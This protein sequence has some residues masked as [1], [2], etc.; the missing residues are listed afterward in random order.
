MERKF[1]LGKFLNRIRCWANEE[2]F[3]PE[4]DEDE[5]EEDDED[6][7]DDLLPRRRVARRN[8][9]T[10]AWLI[11]FESTKEDKLNWIE[12]RLTLPET[13]K[14]KTKNYLL[15]LHYILQIIIRCVVYGDFNLETWDLR[16]EKWQLLRLKVISMRDTCHKN[17]Y[18]LIFFICLFLPNSK[19]QNIP[20][21]D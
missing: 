10:S 2:Y 15:V 8:T 7:K 18:A 17:V 16:L 21:E 19:F 20:L 13:D 5:E 14:N 6:E 3:V 9:W 1:F 4:E 11:L 12:S